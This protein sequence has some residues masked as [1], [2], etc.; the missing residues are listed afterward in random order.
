MPIGSTHCQWEQTANN[1]D[2]YFK[3]K[4]KGSYSDGDI[5]RY[6]RTN[7]KERSL[8]F[9]VDFQDHVAMTTDKDSNEQKVDIL[10]ELYKSIRG[11]QSIIT[12]HVS[13]RNDSRKNGETVMLE[14]GTDVLF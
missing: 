12:S 4:F 10:L 8:H 7:V 2:V 11:I 5:K 14:T 13:R 1:P 3:G 9:P 6:M